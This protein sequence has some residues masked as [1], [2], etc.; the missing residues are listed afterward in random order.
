MSTVMESI[1][2]QIGAVEATM[3]ALEQKI[4]SAIAD[5]RQTCVIEGGSSGACAVAWDIV[6]ELHAEK[7][8]RQ[9]HKVKNNFEMYCDEYPEA[10]ECRIYDV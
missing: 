7:A 1:H 10:E 5:A 3:T 9:Q 2:T 4:Y 8:H 6:E